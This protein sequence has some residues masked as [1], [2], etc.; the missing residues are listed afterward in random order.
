MNAIVNT[1]GH[2][3][4]KHAQW[5]EE[6]RKIPVEIAIREGLYS[7]GDKLHFPFSENGELKYA[8]FR[9]TREK[10]F[11]RDKA[12]AS[13]MLW[14]ID[15]LCEAISKGETLI[16]T[17]GEIDALSWL[18]IGEG[19]V[20]STPDGAQKA[21][22]GEGKIYPSND[23][24][25]SWLWR[26]GNLHPDIDKF[27]RIV[28][29]VDNDE[30]GRILRD[31]L[32]VRLGRKRC[33]V[34]NLPAGCKDANDVLVKHGS[35]RLREVLDTATPLVPDDIRPIIDIPAPEWTPLDTG[36]VGMEKFLRPGC[37]ELM[38]VTGPPGSGKSQWSLALGLNLARLHGIPGAILQFEDSIGR[39]QG[40]IQRYAKI[41]SQQEKKGIHGDPD[42]WIRKHV[43]GVGPQDDD[44][45]DLKWIETKLEFAA[46]RHGCRWAIVDPWNEI[47]HLWDRSK[48]E[49]MYLNEALRSLKMISRRYGLLLMIV[50]HPTKEAALRDITEASLYDIAGGATWYNKA[51]HGIIVHRPN[52]DGTVAHVKIAK[53]KDHLRM[54]RPGIVTMQYNWQSA[55]YRLVCEGASDGG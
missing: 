10:S 26:D 7:I 19:W 42:E 36:W 48:T 6:T 14:R 53:S 55:T 28:L 44:I 33:W 18:A 25:F 3:S 49:A 11:G 12:G 52:P 9:T 16:I 31:E 50:A 40:D 38:I 4:E 21:K 15:A 41:W 17:E 8:K 46:K 32:A 43:L 37:P 30:K 39:L 54:G 20:V 27:E 1:G 2:L 24:A 34:V 47:E 23:G 5:L 29:S 22:P 45:L 51:D 13:T 35:K